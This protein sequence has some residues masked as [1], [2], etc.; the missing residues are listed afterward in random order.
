MKAL[1]GVI[2]LVLVSACVLTA[3]GCPM[4]PGDSRG[5]EHRIYP[6]NEGNIIRQRDAGSYL[7]TGTAWIDEDDAQYYCLFI[8]AKGN[9]ANYFG[10]RGVYAQSSLGPKATA[11]LASD[12]RVYIAGLT[13]RPGGP[14]N[15]EGRLR[16]VNVDSTGEISWDY[17]F[18][19]EYVQPRGI[20]E[21]SDG[22]IVVGAE[23]ARMSDRREMLLA[24]NKDG[25]VAWSTLIGQTPEERHGFAMR[26]LYAKPT[27]GF[28][29]VGLDN[30]GGNWDAAIWAVDAD[31]NDLWY[32]RYDSPGS[33]TGWKVQQASDGGFFV[34]GMTMLPNT[35]DR[36]YLLKL[37]A[38]GEFEW[39]R[40]DVYE[41]DNM[42]TDVEI[43][44]MVVDDDGYIA[45]V[46]DE[47]VVDYVGTIPMISNRSF[48]MRLDSTGTLQ[49]KQNF[50]GFIYGMDFTQQGTYITTGVSKKN[51]KYHIRVLELDKTGKVVN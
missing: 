51:D 25:S 36:A 20:V 38:D 3:T 33:N 7:V 37:D 29:A 39:E 17:T 48:V 34:A 42:G 23:I 16:V 41:P 11:V 12:D 21:S 19:D 14:Y 40:S 27:G 44:D 30:S 50:T 2:Y 31:G 47:E 22:L 43:W 9:I 4:S 26:G 49:W 5:W 10:L 46:G 32:R 35:K 15:F 8:D 45:M 28:F 6:L 13:V 24:L 1:A 18:G